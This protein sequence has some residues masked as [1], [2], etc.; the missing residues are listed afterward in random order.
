MRVRP[1]ND[2][3]QVLLPDYGFV[4]DDK[5]FREFTRE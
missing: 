3:L 4:S 2:L 5:P 1:A